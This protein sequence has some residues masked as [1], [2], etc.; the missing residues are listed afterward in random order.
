MSKYLGDYAEDYATLN[1]KFLTS[2]AE[3][4]FTLAGSPVVKVYKANATGT[5][6]AT[7]VTLTVDF[8]GVTGLNN[9]LIDLSADALYATGEDYH[10]V[11]TTGTVDGDSRVGTVVA[12][13]SIENRFKEVTLADGAQGGSNA[14]LTLK[15]IVVSGAATGVSVSGTTAG[16][17]ID[18]GVTG[19]GLDINGG[20]TSGAAVDI[21][22][23]DGTALAIDSADGMGM[24][25]QGDSTTAALYLKNNHAS[26]PVFNMLTTGSGAA[27]MLTSASGEGMKI[28]GGAED[29]LLNNTGTIED[30]SGNDITQVGAQAALVANNLD[31][32]LKT[33]TG[34]A[35]MTSEMADNTILSRM[36]SNGDTSVF[37]PSADGLQLIRDHA[38]T[39]KTDTA[40]ILADT[41][42]DGVVLAAGEDVYHADI[43]VT[44][45]AANSQDE[46]TVTWFK[47]GV[48]ITSGI[49]NAKIQVVERAAGADLIAQ[50]A[51]S[52]IGSIHSFKYDEATDVLTAGE[53]AVAIVTATIDAA[54]RTFVRVVSR[55]STA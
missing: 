39:I 36:L 9:V 31:H 5:E 21:D 15:N 40:A 13:F 2:K 42:T 14:V 4:P 27:M 33:A 54:T 37:V 23:T 12:D 10:V 43:E 45:D 55:D 19:I 6:T 11:I 18:G 49:T 47:N 8:D 20:S 1:F 53:A 30:G 51:M 29:I 3:I 32:L 52:E 35:D 25:V 16:V 41:G 17:H 50:T 26:G 7:G 24:S 22:A 28:S 44:V 48:R 34:G 38:T 46:Y